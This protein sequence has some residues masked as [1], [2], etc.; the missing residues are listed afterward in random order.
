M[1]GI[2]FDV[3][4]NLGSDFCMVRFR[5]VQLVRKRSEETVSVALDVMEPE[6]YFGE[7]VFEFLFLVSVDRHFSY[8]LRS[9]IYYLFGHCIR[10]YFCI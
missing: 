1:F 5:L 9:M 8:T 4:N 10:V 7:P 6:S 3:T 2:S